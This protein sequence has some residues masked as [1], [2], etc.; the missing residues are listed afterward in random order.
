VAHFDKPLIEPFPYGRQM[1]K[2]SDKWDKARELF[3]Y[4]EALEF[5]ETL[6]PGKIASAT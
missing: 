1:G 4:S 6:P 5:A 3:L 2:T